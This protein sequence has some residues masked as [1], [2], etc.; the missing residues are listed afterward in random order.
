[1]Y[2]NDEDNN[3]NVNSLI[4]SLLTYY[5]KSQINTYQVKWHHFLISNDV[6]KNAYR[7]KLTLFLLM[8]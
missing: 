1:M 4:F 7:D 8:E 6:V 5:L 3:L 2:A